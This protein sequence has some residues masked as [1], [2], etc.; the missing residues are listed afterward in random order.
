MTLS[1]PLW[2]TSADGG[3]DAWG[4]R[5]L[6]RLGDHL[7]SC[8]HARGHD[9]LWQRAAAGTRRFVAAR[10]ISHLLGLML[11]LALALW[12]LA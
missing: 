2:S 4:P 12:L 5:D 8:S 10:P 9:P 6:G 1:R 11:L 7:Q 3:E